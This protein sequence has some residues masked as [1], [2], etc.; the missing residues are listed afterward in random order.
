MAMLI[1]LWQRV[2]EGDEDIREIHLVK[3]ED[4]EVRPDIDVGLYALQL[5]NECKARTIPDESQ[6]PAE[7]L[8][9]SEDEVQPEALKPLAVERPAIVEGTEIVPDQEHHSGPRNI[10]KTVKG[11]LS[12]SLT[13]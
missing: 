1:L 11:S 10:S 13:E 7:P 4:E 5:G 8:G 9:A 3:L 12:A 2:V 6:P